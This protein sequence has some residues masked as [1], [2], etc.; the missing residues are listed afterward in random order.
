MSV[1]VSI[2]LHVK[3]R[4]IYLVL[5][6]ST[7]ERSSLSPSLTISVSQNIFG[8]SGYYSLCTHWYVAVPAQQVLL[9]L[10]PGSHSK[11]DVLIKAEV[12]TAALPGTAYELISDIFS[13]V[14]S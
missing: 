8:N 1:D 11:V 13:C 2:E 10:K 5:Y 3:S 6:G 12:T 14:H 4:F 9:T 7:W